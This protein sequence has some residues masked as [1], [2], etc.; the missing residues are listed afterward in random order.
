[1]QQRDLSPEKLAALIAGLDRAKLAAMSDLALKL[2][3]PDA[4]QRVA[5]ICETLAK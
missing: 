3:R 5:N 4:A 1:M 2:A